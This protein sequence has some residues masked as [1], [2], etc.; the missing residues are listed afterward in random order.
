MKICIAASCHI[1][2][3]RTADKCQSSHLPLT[4]KEGTHWTVKAQIL[5]HGGLRKEKRISP[6]VVDAR[7]D[8][9][10]QDAKREDEKK[11]N[12]W[13]RR[14]Q[15]RRLPPGPPPRPLPRPTRQLPEFRLRNELNGWWAV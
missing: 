6:D 15:P 7:I 5:R 1:G 3:P 8:Q 13:E 12:P 10:R 9:M 14:L 2:C 4:I 11:K